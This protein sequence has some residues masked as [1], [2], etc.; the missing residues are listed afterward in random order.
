MFGFGCWGD[1]VGVVVVGCDGLGGNSSI[2][3]AVRQH[4]VVIRSVHGI[5]KRCVASGLGMSIWWCRRRRVVATL[6]CAAARGHGW[7]VSVDGC[8]T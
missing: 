4:G 7:V 6:V 1:V 5:G 2:G 8:V 3:S